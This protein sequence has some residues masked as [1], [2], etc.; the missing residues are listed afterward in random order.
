MR[1]VEPTSA[2]KFSDISEEAYIS[3]YET[4]ADVTARLPL[5]IEHIYNAKRMHSAIGYVSPNNF[6]VQLVQLAA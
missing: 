3:G 6:K 2:H 5:F 1:F 4:F